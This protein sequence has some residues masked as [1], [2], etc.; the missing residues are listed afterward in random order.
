MPR[1][2]L[3]LVAPAVAAAIPALTLHPARLAAQRFA[4]QSAVVVRADS[5]SPQTAPRDTAVPLRPGR[6]LLDARTWIGI[7]GTTSLGASGERVIVG[8][9]Q[10]GPGSLGVGASVDAYH[11]SANYAGVAEWSENVVPLTAFAAYHLTFRDLPRLDP[12]V[13]VGLGYAVVSVHASTVDGETAGATGGGVFSTGQLGARWYF[14]PTLAVHAQTSFGLGSFGV[15]VSW[16][17]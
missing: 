15:G 16:K 7:N 4:P 1:S 5:A 9:G 10:L 3:S 6:M 8:P 2:R 12:Y 13:G 14:T 11:Y 17:R